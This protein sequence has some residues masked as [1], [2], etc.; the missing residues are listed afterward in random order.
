MRT[1]S[2]NPVHDAYDDQKPGEWTFMIIQSWISERDP[3]NLTGA[4]ILE[5]M[6]ARGTLYSEPFAT[7]YQS[8]PDSTL[9]WHNRL[10]YWVTEPW[11]NHDGTV[12]LVGDAAHPMT[13]RS[14]STT[15][16]VHDYSDYPIDRGQGLN[17]AIH[18][19][20]NLARQIKDKGAKP[21]SALV[22]AL[23]AYEQEM[24]QRG[25]EA[26]I[27]SNENSLSTHNWKELL[28]SPL[29]TAGLQQKLL[30]E[31]SGAGL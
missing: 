6:K 1:S 30:P 27:T 16:H 20:A 12:T 2:H 5:D 3:G 13:F 23:A 8:I 18:D 21:H 11:E 10:S 19:V 25:K 31:D 26:V 9:C 7:I 29:F 22:S 14:S 15:F 17:N 24:W 4:K 28:K